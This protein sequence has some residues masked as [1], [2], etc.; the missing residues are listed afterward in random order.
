[1]YGEKGSFGSDVVDVD[2]FLLVATDVA[3]LVEFDIV[4]D[5]FVAVT[6]VFVSLLFSAQ[7]SFSTYVSVSLILACSGNS[8]Y[9]FK[10]LASS[11]LYLRMTS[12]FSSW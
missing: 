1:M 8:P 2:I 5:V 10:L 7:V 9:A 11:A 6:A 4:V 12:P 3:V